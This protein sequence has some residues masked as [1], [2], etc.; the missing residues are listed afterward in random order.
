MAEY[1]IFPL[2]GEPRNPL[3]LLVAGNSAVSN[4]LP[5]SSITAAWWVSACVSTP[6]TTVRV[7]AMF[8]YRPCAVSDGKC[9]THRPGRADKTVKSY[10]ARSYEV[11]Y[12]Q[13]VTCHASL[14]S[15]STD[16]GQGTE[17]AGQN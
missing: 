10:V 11:T 2:G 14:A 3:G 15:R 16:H 4:N 1:V 8:R 7:R 17:Q 12:V 5:Q 9:G 6:P 13:A